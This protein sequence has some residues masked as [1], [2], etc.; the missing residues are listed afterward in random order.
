MSAPMFLVT[1]ITARR[2]LSWPSGGGCQRRE[3]LDV[4]EAPALTIIARL[5]EA[6]ATICAYDP[7]ATANARRAFEGNPRVSFASTPYE[8][9]AGAHA[10]ALVTEWRVFRGLDLQRTASLMAQ[11]IFFDGR[12]QYEPEG[13]RALGFEYH[14]IGR[15]TP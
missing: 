2:P 10:L 12:N 13:M 1:K 3:R 5:T 11:P 15:A 14:C 9:A 8:A 6:G 7:E 4:R